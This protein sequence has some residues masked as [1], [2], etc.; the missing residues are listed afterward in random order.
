MRS[1]KSAL[2]LIPVIDGAVALS[3]LAQLEM[4]GENLDSIFTLAFRL[5]EQ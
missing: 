4:K 3:S 1:F 2:T 5:I